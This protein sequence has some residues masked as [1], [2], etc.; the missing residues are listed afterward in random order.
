[1]LERLHFTNRADWLAARERQGFGASDGPAIAGCGFITPLEFWKQKTG[2]TAARDL[3]GVE[4]VQEGKRMEPFIREFF[5]GLHPE[6]TITSQPFDIL[7]QRERPWLFCTPD[8]EIADPEGRQGGLEIKNV[9]PRKREEWMEWH[10]QIPQKYYI[11]VLHQFLATGWEYI[12][13]V[14][15]L[16]GMDG[17]VTVKQYEFLRGDVRADMDYYL[18]MAELFRDYVERGIMPPSSLSL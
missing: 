12:W 16:H 2:R 3:S 14:P 4:E 10:E 8:G 9:T 6:L 15:A 17:S 5:K 1:M 11:Q 13:F 18:G 7:F